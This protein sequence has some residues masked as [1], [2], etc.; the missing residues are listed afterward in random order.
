MQHGEQRGQRCCALQH[1]AWWASST[2][3]V[4]D[5]HVGAAWLPMVTLHM[6]AATLVTVPAALEGDA[7]TYTVT[8]A[9]RTG[10]LFQY[11]ETTGNLHGGRRARYVPA[12]NHF[13]LDA[14]SGG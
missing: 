9:P 12:N 10:S 13:G 3:T 1:G 5:V 7:R 2:R 4:D 8:T 11:N 6:N 14:P